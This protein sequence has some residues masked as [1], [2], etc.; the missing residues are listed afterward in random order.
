MLKQ[1]LK[2]KLSQKLSPQQIQ[3]MK[4][5]QLSALELEQKIQ[6]EIGENP[7][8]ETGKDFEENNNNDIDEF[9]DHGEGDNEISVEDFDIDP[10]L[11]DD[12]IPNYKLENSS[13]G[14]LK[15]ET[16]NPFSNQI[17]FHEYLKNQLQ[18][19][20]LDKNEK[21]VAN[22][23]IGSIDNSGY[24]RRSDDDII[25]D[26]AFTQNIIIE[27]SD[28]KKIITKIQLLDPPG[29]A[30]RNL[31]ECL[32]LQLNRKRKN[33][34]SILAKNIIENSFEEFSRKHYKKLQDRFSI[35]ENDLKLVLNEISK[36]N[37]KPG[38]ALSGSVQN[39]HVIP[40][41]ILKIEDGDLKVSLNKRNSPELRISNNYK[42]MLS[43]YIEDPNKTKSQKEAILFIKQKLD[44]AKWFIDAV[45]QRYQTLYLTINAIVEYQREYFLSG[46]EHKLKP[47]VLKDIAEKI[48]MDI[49][50]ISRVANSKYIDT[51]YGVKLLKDFFSEGMKNIEGEDVSTIEIKKTLE[52]IISDEN[53]NKP[54]T[55]NLLSELLKEKGYNVARRTIAKY[56]EQ[57]GFPVA[58]LR[59][60]L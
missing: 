19:L 26:L 37:P 9:S 24:I 18:N 4:L 47:M 58:R 33:K 12:E 46:D 59:K 31:K 51:P 44:A 7:A 15:N 36:L 42:E 60:K 35:D 3:L 20:I 23:I 27:K 22:F 1:K 38:G 28:F 13:Y 10:Y 57:L 14:N 17:S 39:T 30:A 50:T 5:V 16:G 53:K 41:F 43:G 55:D 8:L 54:L 6:S 34:Y 40:D 32:L 11:S 49:S 21:P 29:V 52:S 48:K 25:D 2:L 56:R 45:E